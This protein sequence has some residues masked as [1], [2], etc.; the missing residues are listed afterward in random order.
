MSV[1]NQ[2]SERPIF[3]DGEDYQAYARAVAIY[4]EQLYKESSEYKSRLEEYCSDIFDYALAE[5]SDSG[6]VDY[7]KL[8]SLKDLYMSVHGVP[9]LEIKTVT[10][11]GYLHTEF[12]IGDIQ[13]YES[14]SLCRDSYDKEPKLCEATIKEFVEY[15]FLM[16]D[17]CESID[18]PEFVT[19]TTQNQ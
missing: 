5:L 12:S 15:H 19:Y 2:H 17:Y 14:Y 7:D 10:R 18:Y 13:S 4:A 6:S 9:F 8:K 1:I 16:S 11:K 3:V